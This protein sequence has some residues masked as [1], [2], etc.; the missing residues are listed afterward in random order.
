MSDEQK[1]ILEREL[2]NIADLLRGKMNADEYK[3][4]ILGFIFYKYLSERQEIYV[5][6]E[7]GLIDELGIEYI[8]LNESIPNY[9]DYIKEIETASMNSLG[10]FLK[11]NELFNYLVR[12]A[13]KGEFI[14]EDLKNALNAIENRTFGKESEEDFIG[15]FEDVDLTSPKL[16]K[17]ERDKNEVIVDIFKHLSKIDFDIKNPKS[18]ILG[19]AYEY[20]IGQ[21]AAGSGKKG[22]E[23][24][25]PAKVSEILAQIVTLNRPEIK[26][27]YDPTCGS[28]SLII[29]ARNYAKIGHFY[30]QELNRTTY[31]LARMNM[32]LHGIHYKNFTIRQGDTLTDDK[33]PD[34]KAQAIVANP[35]FSAKWKGKDDPTLAN[36]ERFIP[37]GALAPKSSADYAFVTH[38]LYHLADDGTMAVVLPHGVLFRGGAEEKIRRAIIEKF[39]YLDAVIGLAPNLFYGTSIPACILV[40]KKCRERD[41]I[42]FIDASK[43]YEK[44]KNQNY[45]KEEHIKKIIDTYKDRKEIEKFSHLASLEE[46]RENDYNLN[47]PRYVDIFEEEAPIDINEV[48]KEIKEL[49]SKEKEVDEKIA[50]FCK[51]L[52]IETPF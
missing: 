45:L 11:P 20:L 6:E 46:I 28:G 48:S 30:G 34:L 14:L 50:G 38:M 18:D 15:L 41:D 33:F 7:L 23:F 17:G 32:L 1:R 12:K 37:Y 24:Y 25:T 52:G 39:N 3:N 4:Y 21:F 36:D 22:G 16:G 42:L 8:D 26:S 47:I 40:F 51:E 27:I 31:N 9:D 10:F 44:G 2:W 43:E 35:P 49:E 13:N 29:R 5:N 19:D